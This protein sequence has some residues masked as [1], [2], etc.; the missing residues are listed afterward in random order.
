[1]YLISRHTTATGMLK[2]EFKRF[3][4]EIC[5]DLR[6]EIFRNSQKALRNTTKTHTQNTNNQNDTSLV[7]KACIILPGDDILSYQ[8]AF[9][10]AFI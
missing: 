3:P 7:C 6:E 8:P 1:M 2:D 4:K 9:I 5:H 10:W